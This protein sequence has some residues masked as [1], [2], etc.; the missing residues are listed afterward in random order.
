MIPLINRSGR[1][2]IT[3]T[4]TRNFCLV[5]ETIKGDSISN[6]YYSKY[7]GDFHSSTCFLYSVTI[8][9]LRIT[10]RLT[11]FCF[12]LYAGRLG[13]FR[14]TSVGRKTRPIISTN[15]CSRSLDSDCR[16]FVCRNSTLE[17]RRVLIFFYGPVTRDVG[18][19]ST[20]TNG[21][22]NRS[23]LLHLPIKVRI[24]FRRCRR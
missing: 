16:Y 13:T 1:L 10:H 18:F 19:F 23:L 11:I 8:I 24:R 15:A 6:V 2:L 5:R 14:V 20:R 9:T 4:I 3:A 17:A 12:C 22:I 21:R 7:E